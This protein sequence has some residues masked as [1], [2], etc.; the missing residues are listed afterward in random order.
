MLKASKL[1]D[2]SDRE[3]IL[4]LEKASTTLTRLKNLNVSLRL[5][6]KELESSKNQVPVEVAPTESKQVLGDKGTLEVQELREQL[7]TA[8]QAALDN[9]AYAQEVK[10]Q[11]EELKSSLGIP[12]PEL[13]KEA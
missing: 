9:L 5:R 4:Q 2:M 8:Q 7:K 10:T 6:I 12:E 3:L 1:L 13:I 11:Y